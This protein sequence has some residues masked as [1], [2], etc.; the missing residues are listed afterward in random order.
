MD[1]DFRSLR[2]VSMQS[3]EWEL[4]DRTDPPSPSEDLEVFCGLS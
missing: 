1:G 3:W 4:D 2:G